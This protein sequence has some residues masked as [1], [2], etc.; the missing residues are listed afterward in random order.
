MKIVTAFTKMLVLL[1]LMMSTGCGTFWSQLSRN[2][3]SGWVYLP[4]GP[5]AGV[6]TDVGVAAALA[7]SYDSLVFAPFALA[8]IPCSAIADTCMLPSYIK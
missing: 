8:D 7:T 2:D 6:V 3:N 4:T 1:S 5:Y